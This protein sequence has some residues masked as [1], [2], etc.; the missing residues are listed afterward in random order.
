M[1]QARWAKFMLQ[2][3]ERKQLRRQ[4]IRFFKN[5]KL[6]IAYA[7]YRRAIA[8]ADWPQVK[9]RAFPVIALAARA[10]DHRTM[11]EMVKTLERVG[12]YH[13]SAELW[14]RELAP[15]TKLVTNEWRGEAL[16]GKTVLINFNLEGT[17][18]LGVGYRF[19]H[20][21]PAIMAQAKRTLILLEP[22]QAPTFKRTYPL[23]EIFTSP[24][25]V[26]A[27]NIDY[28]AFPSFL[29]AKFDTGA[30]DTAA[31][32]FLQPDALKTAE[33]REKYQVMSGGKPLI[34]I[35]WYSS[36]YGKDVPTLEQWRDFIART[37]ATFVSLQYGDVA[38]DL[39][40]IGGHRIIVDSE[41]DQL[42]NMDDF[43]AQ[44]VAMDG[45][46]T[47]MNT[48]VNVGSSLGVPT[49]V[50]RDDW[51]RR[52]LPHLGDRLPYLP[53][54][55]AVGKNRRPWDQV[56]DQAFHTLEELLPRH[57]GRKISNH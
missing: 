3:D 41:I 30:P 56:L 8:A 22:R 2:R 32:H 33:L 31:I 4:L 19:A 13:E 7:R 36:H 20:I 21:I 52:N 37:D 27:K 57:R 10:R 51:F 43:A 1:S 39:K 5:P 49:V 26:P 35:S 12:C 54:L 6:A 29:K 18:G 42:V 16:A 50:L 34:G 55:R 45:V 14:L 15:H 53:T 25:D 24:K 44:V 28:V 40:I 38:N 9:E 11:D 46:I 17:H 23:L 47:I 48:L